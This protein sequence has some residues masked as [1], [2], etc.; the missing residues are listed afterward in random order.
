MCMYICVCVGG[1]GGVCII[2]W[3]KRN[4]NVR[5]YVIYY[6]KFLQQNNVYMVFFL[7]FLYFYFFFVLGNISQLQY[8]IIKNKTLN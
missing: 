8:F 7:F 6:N 1:G 4:I 5:C 2:Y 3:R